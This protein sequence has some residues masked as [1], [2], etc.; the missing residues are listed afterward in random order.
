[1]NRTIS[2]YELLSRIGV[3]GMGEVYRA[4]DTRL[5]RTVALKFLTA[6]FAQDR[7]RLARFQREAQ[8]L[9]SLNHPH[10]ASLY[11]F[12]EAE[13]TPFLVMELAEGESLDRRLERGPMPLDEVLAAALQI[14]QAL[15]EAHDRGVVHRDLKPGNVHITDDGNVKVLDFGLA[16]ALEA[17]SALEGAGTIAQSPTITRMTAAGV[18]LGTAAYMSPEQAKG[19]SADRRSDVWSF[20]VVLLEMLTGRRV[21][22]GETISETLAS[23][24]KDVVPLDWL[25]EYTP[26]ALRGLLTRCLER[27]PKRRLQAIGEARI[28]LEALRSGAPGT[29]GSGL[30]AS[31]TMSGVFPVGGMLSSAAGGDGPDAVKRGWTRWL[32]WAVAALGLGLGAVAFVQNSG[33]APKATEA[34]LRKFAIQTGTFDN[35]D[36]RPAVVSP[37]GRRVAYIHGSGIW[38]QDLFSLEARPLVEA[39]GR[40]PGEMP[41]NPIWSPDSRQIAYIAAGRLW[42]I[43]AEGGSPTAVCTVGEGVSG[44]TWLA[45][46]RLVYSVPR[47]DILAVSSRGGD[48]EV[49]LARDVENDV[50]FHDPW[51]LPDGRGVIYVLHR[52]E[53]VDTIELFADGKRRQLLRIPRTETNSVQVVNMVCYAPSGHLLYFRE[54]GNR[55]VWAVPFSLGSLEVTG[56]PFLVA[57]YGQHPSISDDG[58]LLYIP[59]REETPRRLVWVN[60]RGEVGETVVDGLRG[61]STPSL[62]PDGTRVAYAAEENGAGEIWIQDLAGGTRTRL[63]FTQADESWPVWIPGQNRVAFMTN[64]EGHSTVSAKSADGS[65]DVAVLVEDG[66]RPVFTAD[67]KWMIFQRTS[68]SKAGLLRVPVDGSAESEMLIPG[69]RSNVYSPD[70]STDGRYVSYLS[71]EQG[72]ATTYIRPFPTGEG[73]WELP[74]SWES[75]LCWLPDR[76]VYTTERPEPAMMEIPVDLAGS[77][78]L[79]TPRKLFDL[80]PNRLLRFASFATAADGSRFLMVQDTADAFEVDHLALVEN[81]TAEFRQTPAPR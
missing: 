79:G 41:N 66:E 31:G 71:W 26:P 54:Q 21:F 75:S 53:G 67:G 23:I 60:T 50:D 19:R 68:D 46:D 51:A 43:P 13:G 81:W 29:S 7:E 65:G 74:G 57:A 2:H 28:T 8:V 14:A 80:R 73:K 45:D 76:I 49:Y 24:L 77:L 42:K 18:I 70:L 15:E 61:L 5:G 37:D 16:K 69:S 64:Q 20:G 22:E 4:R 10:I 11:G 55:G 1:M 17:D 30:V 6:A 27:D 40:P 59:G 63:T 72:T 35:W 34:P 44:G 52:K 78:S 47:G 48:P 58:T 56:D 9:A 25:P 3:G 38:V 39:P 62:S 36:R 12:E 32:P 33:Q